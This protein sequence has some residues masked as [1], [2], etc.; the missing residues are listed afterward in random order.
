LRESSALGSFKV[1]NPDSSTDY[2]QAFC[3]ESAMGK[4]RLRQS[5]FIKK[6]S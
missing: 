4:G 2:I 6:R 1:D 5:A 3:N